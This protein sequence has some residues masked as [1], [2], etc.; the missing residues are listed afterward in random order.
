MLNTSVISS[1]TSPAG[2][3]AL[4]ADA[5]VRQVTERHLDDVG[6]D[7]RGRFERI[8]GELRLLA[9]SDRHHHGLAHGAR[10]AQDVRGRDPE[11]APGTT[12]AER[13]LQARRAHRVGALAHVIGTARIASS[14][15]ELTYGMIMIPITMPAREHVE[16]GQLGISAAGAA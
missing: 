5:V 6:R 3:D 15:T 14:L 7:G 4:V 11:K 9:G 1:S 8:E 12:T 10:D 2:E 16:A 13:C